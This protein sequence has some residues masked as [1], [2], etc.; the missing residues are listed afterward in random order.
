VAK[1]RRGA[2]LVITKT[3]GQQISG[4]LIAVKPSSLLL[5]DSQTG[6]DLSIKIEEIAIIKI[7]KKSKAW[8]IGAMGLGV[9]AVFGLITA[10]DFY[11]S[12]MDTEPTTRDYIVWT[13]ICVPFFAIPGVLIGAFLGTDKTIHLA[14]KSPEETRA[15]LDK[16][17]TQARI[18]NFQ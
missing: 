16:L 14:G 6:G 15:A 4:E 7:I 13:A 17:R 5:L 9:G 1:E 12:V 8:T 10:S 3:D 2:D 18:T 11:K